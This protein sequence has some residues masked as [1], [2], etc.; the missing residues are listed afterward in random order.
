M[1]LASRPTFSQF[2]SLEIRGSAKFMKSSIVVG[3]ILKFRS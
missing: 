2:Q 1:K 3:R